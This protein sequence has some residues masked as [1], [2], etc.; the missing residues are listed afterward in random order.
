LEQFFVNPGIERIIVVAHAGWTQYA[1]DLLRQYDLSYKETAVI[2]GGTNKTES[3][4]LIARYI[5]AEYGISE[6][7]AL[8][9]HDAIRPFIT[10]RIIDDHIAALSLYDAVNTAGLTND[11][12]I[13]SSDGENV[14]DVPSHGH[15]YAEQTPQSYSLP[16][17]MELLAKADEQKILLA[18]ESELPRLWLKLGY[19]MG[20]VM[21]EYSN[22]KII[23]PYDLEVAEA[24]LRETKE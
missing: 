19:G 22:M 17:L 18:Q 20:M 14:D 15:M 11:A 12:I 3:I 10:Q 24:L 9:A 7:D 6:G 8:I 13:F 1:E 23:N 16:K 5:A 2:P 21:G 4:G